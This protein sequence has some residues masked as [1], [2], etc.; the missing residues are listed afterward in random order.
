[1][2]RGEEGDLR[3][4]K[5]LFATENCGKNAPMPLKDGRGSPSYKGFDL[6]FIIYA[7]GL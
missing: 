6:V 3:P 5:H 1:M 7:S 4:T 2:C